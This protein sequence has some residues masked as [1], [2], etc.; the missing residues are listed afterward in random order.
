MPFSMA[1]RGELPSAF[2]RV[3]PALRTPHVAIIAC[4]LV[5]LTLGL[6][7]SFAATSTLSAIG[8]LVVY[9]LTCAALMRL[10]RKDAPPAGFVLPGGPI[11]AT[12]GIVF[13]IWLLSTRSFAQAWIIAGIVLVGALVRWS[14]RRGT[15]AP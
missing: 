12:I 11:F 4:S 7:G 8:R 1:E 5:A 2:A 15:P 13:S 3:H 9:G 10:R 6:A 14:V